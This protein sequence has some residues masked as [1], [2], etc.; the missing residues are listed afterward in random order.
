[1]RQ[2]RLL[3]GAAA[4]VS[5]ALLSAC[6]APP[7]PE[8]D[9]RHI[10]AAEFEGLVLADDLDIGASFDTTF[11]LEPLRLKAP[12]IQSFW[13]ESDGDPVECLDSYFASYILRST[14]VGDPNDDEFADI[15]G[16]YPGENGAINVAGRS[17]ESEDAAAAFLETVPISADACTSAGGYELYQG[18]GVVGWGVTAVETRVPDSFPVPDGVRVLEQE[19]TVTEGFALRYRVILLQFDNAIV[20][21]TAQLHSTSTFTFEQVDELAGLVAARLVELR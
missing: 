13:D 18:D 7:E 8:P 11:N 2:R 5:V 4:L 3:A 9:A 12:S 14:E 17:F 20:A 15:A 10:T 16:Y 19:E 1:M 21:V 6:S